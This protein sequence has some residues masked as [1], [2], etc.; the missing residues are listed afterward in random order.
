MKLLSVLLLV[1]ALSSAVQAFMPQRSGRSVNN[2]G[3]KRSV[4]QMAVE[5]NAFTRAN[6]AARSAAADARVIELRMPLGLELDEVS[7]SLN[8]SILLAS[9]VMWSAV[10]S[11]SIMLHNIT[12]I[13]YTTTLLYW[14]L[15]LTSFKHINIHI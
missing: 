4:I 6:R 15:T 7:L 10:L 1:V 11:S 2:I 3:V 8:F 14:Y 9:Y 12:S 13:A 5:D